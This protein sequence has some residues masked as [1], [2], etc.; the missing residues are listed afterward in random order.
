MKIL[1]APMNY[2]SK[3]L[4][5]AHK[6]KRLAQAFDNA[7][8]MGNPEYHNKNIPFY[9]IKNIR[10]SS[11]RLNQN[12][13]L[14]IKSFDEFLYHYKMLDKISCIEEIETMIKAIKEYKPD[15][16]YSHYNINAIIAAQLTNTKCY[17]TY[18][19]YLHR[20]TIYAK[21]ISALNRILSYYQLPQVLSLHELYEKLDHRFIFSSLNYQ[22][23]PVD[24]KTTFVGEDLD[25]IC[26]SYDK[27][28]VV[29]LANA[30]I[31][32]NKQLKII[33][34]AFMHSPYDVQMY[35]PRLSLQA[36]N[37]HV[38]D[39][40]IMSS[41][42]KDACVFIHDGSDINTYLALQYRIPQIIISNNFYP[43]QANASIMYK[44]NGAFR[45]SQSLFS[46]K[47]IY[48]DFKA[49]VDDPKY[50]KN[51]QELATYFQQFGGCKKIKEIIIT[52]QKDA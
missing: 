45:L 14:E 28:I 10:Y 29:N 22:P 27:K 20:K 51:M 32:D 52:N 16:I 40:L 30:I 2:I 4:S 24:D 19:Y 47:Y 8:I 36:Y 7:A 48:E 34:E 43:H 46:V 12:N 35:S 31:S 33:K 44:N 11:F 15:A 38:A 37:F 23:I 5:C 18:S 13:K 3:N 41:V 6:I 42:L 21:G 26:S 17:G 25:D 50:Q 49:L 1:I 39:N 9:L